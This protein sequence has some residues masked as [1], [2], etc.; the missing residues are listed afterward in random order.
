MN[1]RSSGQSG[2]PFPLLEVQL[3][4]GLLGDEGRQRESTIHA[5]SDHRAFPAERADREVEQLCYPPPSLS[6]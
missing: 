6:P 2:H 3:L 1:R 4:T 5:E